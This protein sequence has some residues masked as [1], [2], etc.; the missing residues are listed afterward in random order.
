MS[1]ELISRLEQDAA[2]W[3]AEG[4]MNTAALLREA[5]AALQPAAQPVAHDRKALFD[6]IA[7]TD[8]STSDRYSDNVAVA[9]C[10]YFESHG[11]RPDDDEP[12]GD[13]Q[14]W[15]PWVLEQRN[16]MLARVREEVRQCEISHTGMCYGDDKQ[17]HQIQYTRGWGDC[18]KAIK[19]CF[20]SAPQEPT[21]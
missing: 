5:A 11:A 9:L 4:Y 13:E 15:G 19:K 6:L 18:L 10:S 20:E 8:A 1:E 3:A 2:R 7:A 17:G 12:E 14:C 16:R 21:T